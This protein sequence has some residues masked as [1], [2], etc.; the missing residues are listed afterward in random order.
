MDNICAPTWAGVLPLL[1]YTIATATE[2]D[3]GAE[4]V[5]QLQRLADALDAWN[6]RVP[7]LRE[8]L[9]EARDAVRDEDY[10]IAE[11]NIL[12]ALALIAGDQ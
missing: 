10:R 8:M 9:H 1:V 4:S 6:A 2:S 5:A 11:E 3:E 7:V 12:R